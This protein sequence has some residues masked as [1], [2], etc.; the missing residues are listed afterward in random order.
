MSQGRRLSSQSSVSRFRQST[1]AG[2]FGDPSMEFCNAFWGLND[3]GVDVLFARMRIAAKSIDELRAFWKERA[4]IE[5]DY[6]KRL[7]RL[8]K[9][10]LG[11]GEIGEL[12]TAL[13]SVRQET[14]RQAGQHL[15]LSISIH[16]EL[17]GP[18]NEFANKQA[19]HKRTAQA[20]VEKTFKQK[21]LNETYVAKAKERYEQDCHR[22]NAYSAQQT[23]VQGRELEKIA[24]KL[25]RAQ[26]TVEG[27]KR[28]YQNFTRALQETVTRWDKEWK[29]FCDRCQDLEEERLEFMK[30]NIWAYANAVSTVCVNEDESCEAMRLALERLEVERDMEFFIRNHGTGP[31]IPEA[32][33]F[34]SYSEADPTPVR[35]ATRHANFARSTSRPQPIMDS[36]LKAPP[37][38]EDDPTDAGDA[39]VGA[40][41][42]R[43]GS[44]SQIGTNET[45][46]GQL[47]P[48]GPPV[49]AP[50]SGYHH[51]TGS[52]G[53]NSGTGGG[54]PQGMP[55]MVPPSN[56]PGSYQGPSP[57]NHIPNEAAKGL[58][59]YQT[60]PNKDPQVVPGG[61]NDP[62]AARLAQLREA[63]TGQSVRRDGTLGRSAGQSHNPPS[64]AAGSNARAVSPAG[65]LVP[66]PGGSVDYSASADAIVGSH[67]SSR[68]SSPAQLS[69]QPHPAMMNPGGARAPSPVEA[70]VSTYGQAFPGERRASR[71]NSINTQDP[72]LQRGR[73]AESQ[74]VPSPNPGGFAGVGAKGRSPSPQPFKQLA[75]PGPPVSPQPQAYH[76]PPD[77]GRRAV[78]PGLHTTPSVSSRRAPSPSIMLDENGNVIHD[79][80]A[81]RFGAPPNGN[82][83]LRAPTQTAPNPPPPQMNGA[84]AGYGGYYPPGQGPQNSIQAVSP[85]QFAPPPAPPPL[86]AQQTNYSS[87]PS[88]AP[89]QTAGSYAP[90][91]PNQYGSGQQQYPQSNVQPPQVQPVPPQNVYPNINNS[92]QDYRGGYPAPNQYG[93]NG[94]NANFPPNQP[95]QPQQAP[96]QYAGQTPIP[97]SSHP[98]SHSNSSPTLGPAGRI[99]DQN[100]LFYVKALYDYNATIPEEFDFQAGDVI[101]VLATPDDGWWQGILLDDSR[102]QPGRTTFPSN[103]VCLF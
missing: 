97:T 57:P 91:P 22:V 76:S 21:Q 84:Q 67:P 58:G 41:Y 54:Y 19:H 83:P 82:P 16:R 98:N 66:P 18:V 101:A 59:G 80:M 28:D 39:G 96:Q 35:P 5:E 71:S 79:A 40:G 52:I 4:A 45:G 103:F 36:V 102:R 33:Q 38:R 94:I 56:R 46:P 69:V 11:Q 44:G 62:L 49:G 34:I 9:Q 2:E 25:E 74:R 42:N 32:P 47:P 77:F 7:L 60:G 37:Q 73:P 86:V 55:N 20:S 100:I 48:F 87:Y 24:I 85:G 89:Q 10:P 99:E 17:E 1:D 78:S 50:S 26:S 14:E 8:A 30:D 75:S 70:V 64:S 31:A 63:P 61:P 68:P 23:L 53:S 27:N 3:A 95:Q 12:K 15:S 81:Q 43:A 29:E 65:A 88:I 92:Q 72:N 6:A 93:P 13:D 51:A 90:P